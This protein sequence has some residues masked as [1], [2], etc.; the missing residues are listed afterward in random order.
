MSV[1]FGMASPAQKHAQQ[2]TMPNPRHK[3]AINRYGGRATTSLS[4]WNA[5][6]RRPHRQL[7]H[8]TAVRLFQRHHFLVIIKVITQCTTQCII[9]IK[10]MATTLHRIRIIIRTNIRMRITSRAL[11]CPTQC[12][13]QR[14]KWPHYPQIRDHQDRRHPTR[15]VHYSILPVE[16]IP[17]TIVTCT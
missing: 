14:S 7:R 13:R 10:I 17:R 12:D 4:P 15:C 2:S 3:W 5:S 6:N 9:S 8:R 1:A 16:R 11:T